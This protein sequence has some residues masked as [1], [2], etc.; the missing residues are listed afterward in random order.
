MQYMTRICHS[1]SVQILLPYKERKKSEST[2]SLLIIK[3]IWVL[4]QNF[5]L[6]GTYLGEE[7]KKQKVMVLWSHNSGVP[8]LELGSDTM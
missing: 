4:L 5:N 1:D 7:D 3:E 8:G 2:W 6:I